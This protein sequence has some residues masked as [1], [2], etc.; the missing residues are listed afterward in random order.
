M[1][2]DFKPDLRPFYNIILVYR[3]DC[4]K[5]TMKGASRFAMLLM[6]AFLGAWR[7]RLKCLAVENQGNEIDTILKN[8]FCYFFVCG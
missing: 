8:I 5:G 1:F 6:F 4:S 2:I 7:L 3:H